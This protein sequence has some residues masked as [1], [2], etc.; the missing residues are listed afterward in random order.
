MEVTT[1]PPVVGQ[2]AVL[3]FGV[4]WR[5]A[6]NE[7]APM[8]QALRAVATTAG[9]DVLFGR[10]Q[11]EEC[12]ELIRYYDVY[13]FPTVVLLNSDGQVVE[14]LEGEDTVAQVEQSVQRFLRDEMRLR[15]LRLTLSSEVML[16]IKGTPRVP[17]C[18]FS[19]RAVRLLQDER[20][21]FGSFDVLTDETVREE[22]KTYANC[23]TYPQLYVRG[24]FVG[25][26]DR[27]M[28]IREQEGGLRSQL[29]V[30]AGARMVAL[31]TSV[32][33]PLRFE[34]TD[35]RSEWTLYLKHDITLTAKPTILGGVRTIRVHVYG[36]VSMLVASLEIEGVRIASRYKRKSNFL[37]RTG[38]LTVE[39]TGHWEGRRFELSVSAISR[40]AFMV[41]RTDVT[42][43]IFT[44]AGLKEDQPQG[45]AEQKVIAQ[46]IYENRNAE[47]AVV[48]WARVF[49][50]TYTVA[51]KVSSSLGLDS[52]V[53]E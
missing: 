33:P 9:T 20:I 42:E 10:V 27:M 47:H 41:C 15:L 25:G 35:S 49:Y 12:L 23:P 1:I 22:L 39:L 48:E 29:R 40:R 45:G 30:T 5:K 28:E 31:R 26:A 2:T 17:R 6:C 53:D 11:A 37:R 51:K 46:I 52:G 13:I 21:P 14:K 7:G 18:G 34:L 43:A 38:A 44:L 16:F 32:A 19:Q 4:G 3:L 50:D 8:D 24:K 36:N